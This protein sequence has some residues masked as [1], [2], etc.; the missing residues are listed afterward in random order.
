ME[1][2]NM[3]EATMDAVGSHVSLSY[4]VFNIYTS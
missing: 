1:H 4:A 2:D 3:G